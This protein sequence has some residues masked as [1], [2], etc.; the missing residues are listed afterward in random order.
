MIMK[1]VLIIAFFYFSI[2]L[3]AQSTHSIGP[4]L[5]AGMSWVK[6]DPS[7]DGD[8]SRIGFQ[9]GIQYN[10]SFTEHWGL[11]LN[12][13][14]QQIGNSTDLGVDKFTSDLNYIRLPIKLHYYF[15][16]LGNKI[17]PNVFLGPSMGYLLSAKVDGEDFKEFANV[18]DLGALIGVGLNFNIGEEKWLNFDLGYTHG[19]SDLAKDSEVKSQNGALMLNV[20][21]GF[22][23]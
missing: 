8:K 11:G 18:F 7:F 12:L 1:K 6:A 5:G 23:L 13:L 2:N 4:V 3:S 14:F 10:Y 9:G 20:G 17:R 15:G 21:L 19:I 22:G 16:H